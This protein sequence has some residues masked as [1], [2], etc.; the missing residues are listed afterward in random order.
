MSGTA[1][2]CATALWYRNSA[3]CYAVCT[4]RAYAATSDARA[5]RVSPTGLSYDLPVRYAMSATVL[6]RAMRCP[7]LT[8]GVLGHAP[9]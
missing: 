7:L 8:Y 5:S 2:A 1:I 6:L 4:V 3:C 9:H